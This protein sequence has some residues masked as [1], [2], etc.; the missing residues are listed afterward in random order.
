[1]TT[2][3]PETTLSCPPSAVVNLI[4][5]WPEVGEGDLIL[6]D[7]EFHLVTGKSDYDGEPLVWLDGEGGMGTIPLGTY[8]AVR[9]YDTGEG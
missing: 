9:R 6:W 1:M 8:V 3:T 4:L 5:A 2:T 7:G